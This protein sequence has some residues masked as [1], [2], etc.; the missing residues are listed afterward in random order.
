MTRFNVLGIRAYANPGTDGHLYPLLS[1]EEGQ[2][3]AREAADGPNIQLFQASSAAV[4]ALTGRMPSRLATTYGPSDGFVSDCRVAL[5]CE[6]FTKGSTWIGV[7]PGA[8]IAGTAMAV[9]ALRAR[10]RRKGKIMV[11]QLRYEWIGRVGVK[12]RHLSLG[13]SDG[14]VP[15]ELQIAPYYGITATMAHDIA[16]RVAASRLRYNTSLTG[17]QRTTLEG[18]TEAGPMEPAAK[19]RWAHYEL[20]G[21]V[22]VVT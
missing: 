1:E 10:H 15:K 18:I 7:G 14:G 11:G 19:G 5:S 3:I 6:K 20:P 21:A 22:M 17:D 13:Y 9:S 8:A 16:Q 2:V 4:Y 12:G